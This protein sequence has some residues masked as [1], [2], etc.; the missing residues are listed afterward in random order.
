MVSLGNIETVSKGGLG[1]N[2]RQSI[3]KVG[4]DDKRNFLT[5]PMHDND[6]LNFQG[7]FG[8][9]SLEWKHAHSASTST[10]WSPRI[11][12]PCI[13]YNFDIGLPASDHLF[14]C[15]EIY[16]DLFLWWFYFYI[17]WDIIVILI[18]N[19]PP[20]QVRYRG[21]LPAA[22]ETQP[23]G[24]ALQKG[25]QNPPQLLRTALQHCHCPAPVRA[26]PPRSWHPLQGLVSPGQQHHVS[27]PPCQYLA[28]LGAGPRCS[29][30]PQSPG[31]NRPQGGKCPHAVRK[32]GLTYNFI[33]MLLYFPYN[34]I[35]I[36]ATR[37]ANNG[38]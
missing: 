8:I 35:S 1:C 16:I 21:G 18:N 22:G 17:E 38:G 36:A 20:P 14:L 15:W 31:G 13:W 12:A 9:S 10:A 26:L 34:F 2:Q 5:T 11:A 27:L 7:N 23:R 25:P 33:S 3:Q 28:G 24:G 6:W 37:L 30:W 32:S 4:F 19:N 29:V